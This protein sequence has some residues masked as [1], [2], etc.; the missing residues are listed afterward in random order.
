MGMLCLTGKEGDGFCIGSEVTVR[1]L[2]VR[3]DRVLVGIDAPRKT[4][5]DREAVRERKEGERT[6][7]KTSGIRLPRGFYD[8]SE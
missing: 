1:I 4:E 7:E 5:V 3:G 8:D 6:P 2:R